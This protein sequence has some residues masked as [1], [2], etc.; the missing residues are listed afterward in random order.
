MTTS[1]NNNSKVPTWPQMLQ[2]L[3][4]TTLIDRFHLFYPHICLCPR[5]FYSLFFS[6]YP[7]VSSYEHAEVTCYP[8]T[9]PQHSFVLSTNRNNACRGLS[10]FHIKVT[11]Q[12]REKKRRRL[13][14]LNISEGFLLP[15]SNDF[16]ILIFPC[17][18]EELLHCPQLSWS[19]SKTIEK[20]L[21]RCSV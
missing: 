15:F 18:A 20:M 1:L 12:N 21:V 7:F 8:V 17:D 13:Y 11:K 5:V 19:H 10:T 4:V 3:K 9:I 6:F 14:R 2:Y 16:S